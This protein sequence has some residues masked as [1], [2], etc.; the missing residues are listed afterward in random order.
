MEV[1]IMLLFSSSF[2]LVSAMCIQILISYLDKSHPTWLN[3]DYYL[4]CYI[5]VA[6]SIYCFILD[7]KQRFKNKDR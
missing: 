2:L 6:F 7:F 1:N 5:L 4:Y 3:S